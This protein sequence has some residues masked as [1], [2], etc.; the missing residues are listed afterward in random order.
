MERG[1]LMP[2]N[3]FNDEAVLHGSGNGQ[4]LKASLVASAP[5]TVIV[6][7][8]AADVERIAVCVC[9]CVCVRVRVRACVRTARSSATRAPSP[10]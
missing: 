8:T 2:G 6:A 5:N 9:V 10:R 1:R 4:G 3:I 7:F